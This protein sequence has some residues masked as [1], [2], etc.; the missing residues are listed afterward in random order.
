MD[1]VWRQLAQ[2]QIAYW[3]MNGATVTGYGF[4]PGLA[5]YSIIGTGDF[6]GDGRFD[7]L[8]DNGG[9]MYVWLSTGTDFD[10]Q[11]VASYGD[12]WVPWRNALK[13]Q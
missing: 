2:N 13:R 3:F 6:N 1:I 4:R 5:G 9:T 7:I 11:L 12:G 10:S 8:W